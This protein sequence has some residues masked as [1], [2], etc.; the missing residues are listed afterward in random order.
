MQ[1][2][3]SLCSKLADKKID[4]CRVSTGPAEARNKSK[5]DRIAGNRK[6]DR[7]GRSC[8]LRSADRRH[9][10]SY[11]YYRHLATHKLKGEVRE[12]IGTVFRPAVFHRDRLAFDK[13][14][15]AEALS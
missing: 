13:A 11:D 7:N 5:L 15:F 14:H 9:A 2:S 12:P 4:P 8:R 1:E 3:K 10:P 6:H